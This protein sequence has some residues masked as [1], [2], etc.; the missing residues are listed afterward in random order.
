MVGCVSRFQC[1]DFGILEGSEVILYTKDSGSYGYVSVFDGNSPSMVTIKIFHQV[2]LKGY[3]NEDEGILRSRSRSSRSS[4]RSG[5]VN[6]LNASG[7][8]KNRFFIGNGKEV[9]SWSI[10]CS[11]VDK[12]LLVQN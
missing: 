11:F 8:S 10:A 6:Q 12:I 3:T 2:P 7:L 9:R 5:E 4:A 1:P